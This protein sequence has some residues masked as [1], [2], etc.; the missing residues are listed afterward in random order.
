LVGLIVVLTEILWAEQGAAAGPAQFGREESGPGEWVGPE[1]ERECFF[2]FSEM[3]KLCSSCF[4][5][6]NEY[7]CDKIMKYFVYAY[8]YALSRKIIRC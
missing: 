3:L 8:S 5:H 4:I 1:R 2:F 7:K 6:R